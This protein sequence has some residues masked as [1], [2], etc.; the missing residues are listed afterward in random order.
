MKSRFNLAVLLIL[1]WFL[2]PTAIASSET[3][4]SYYVATNDV[5]PALTDIDASVTLDCSAVFD[6][7]DGTVFPNNST[8]YPITAKPGSGILTVNYKID[9]P[10]LKKS[11]SP[12]VPINATW[13]LGDSPPITVYDDGAIKIT[14]IIHG[15]LNG[16]VIALGNG[17]AT[18]LSVTWSTWKTM[19]IT[20]SA[21]VNAQNGQTIQIQTATKYAVY[22][23]V[24]VELIGIASFTQDS[25]TKEVSG[26]PPVQS[27]ILVVEQNQPPTAVILSNP[28]G[29]TQNSMKLTWTQ[30]TE[31]D[32]ARY[33]IYKSTSS[34]NLGTKT[35]IITDGTTTSYV[36]TGLS[37][38]TTY[39]FTVRVMDTG[40]LYTDSN[41]VSGKATP[42]DITPP[43][44]MIS[45][46]GVVGDNDWFTSDVQVT[47]S[48]TDENEI[49]KT[50]YS[51]D[52]ATWTLYAAPFIISE[53]GSTIVYYKSTD[54]AGNPETTKTKTIKIDKNIPLGSITIN[55]GATFTTSTSVTLTLNASDATSG[56]YRVRFS[57]NGTWDTEPWE[58]LSSTKTWQLTTGDGT[59]AVYYQVKDNAGLVSITYSDTI[60][61]DTVPPTGSILIND[62]ATHTNTTTVILTLSATDA[63]SGIA[64]MRFS[65]N[66]VTWS[67]WGAY[68]TSKTWTLTTGDGTK[69]V[70]VQIRDQAGLISTHSDTIILDTTRP[71]AEAP[72]EVLSIWIIVVVVAAIG[73]TV[74]ATLLLRKRK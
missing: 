22:F 38:D 5:F 19:D 47:L 2:V 67:D 61:L 28:S 1:L 27:V 62:G 54:K 72:T 56:A 3:T 71:P 66:N 32:F 17:S 64:E 10:L 13:L 33:E 57:N 59:K 52:N 15:H 49:D 11:G 73:I 43:S 37:A 51:L 34:G 21:N 23:T 30:N 25:P 58:T 65:N 14:V 36:V 50:E 55:N 60:I 48:A 40:G 41:Q 8:N 42:A 18:P 20:V 6:S 53:E 46:N 29:I 9:R 12:S 39:Y 24:K 74:A 4:V 63:T 31:A 35:Y 7:S 69:T 26:S 45:L 68:A 70:Y 16:Q 44:T